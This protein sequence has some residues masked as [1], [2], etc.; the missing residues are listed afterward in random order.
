MPMMAS[1]SAAPGGAAAAPAAVPPMDHS[2]MPGMDHSAMPSTAGSQTLDHSQMGRAA[3][4]G[5]DS[6]TTPGMSH[7][8]MSGMAMNG[9]A[10]G[11]GTSRLPQAEGMMPGVHFDLGG[12]WTGMAH[13]YA[14]PVLHLR[15]AGK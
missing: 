4:T 3:M 5:M 9:P 15:A 2:T 6:P 7:S 8:S 12:G 1:K 11:S 14:G 13:G 10:E